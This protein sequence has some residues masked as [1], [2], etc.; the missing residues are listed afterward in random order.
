MPYNYNRK[1]LNRYTTAARRKLKLPIDFCWKKHCFVLQH[2]SKHRMQTRKK[3][4]NN[5]N[6][7]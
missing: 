3:G 2:G 1:H 5:E 6:K 7:I 4:Q